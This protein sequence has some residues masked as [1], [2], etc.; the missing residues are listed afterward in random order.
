MLLIHFIHLIFIQFVFY[1]QNLNVFFFS[2][3][4][5]PTGTRDSITLNENLQLELH[6]TPSQPSAQAQGQMPKGVRAAG[7]IPKPLHVITAISHSV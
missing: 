7:K 6:P 4:F 1:C 5:G 3:G 2:F